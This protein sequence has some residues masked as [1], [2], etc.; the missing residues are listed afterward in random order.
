MSSTPTVTVVCRLSPLA[1][2]GN[3]RRFAALS[4]SH[5]VDAMIT[6]SPTLAPPSALTTKVFGCVSTSTALSPAVAVRPAKLFT[7]IATCGR[8]SAGSPLNLMQPNSSVFTS[9][10]AERSTLKYSCAP[11][12]LIGWNAV[13]AAHSLC[14]FTSRKRS[15]SLMALFAGNTSFF[16]LFSTTAFTLCSVSTAVPS[17]TPT[18]PGMDFTTT[19]LLVCTGVSAPKA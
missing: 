10:A 17:S 14:D 4:S 11:S 5:D 2:T 9:S 1:T 13:A 6:L 12:E 8:N 16:S 7:R 18:K 19:V 3:T 15:L